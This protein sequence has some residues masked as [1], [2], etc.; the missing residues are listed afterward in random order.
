MPKKKNN[1]LSILIHEK[2]FFNAKQAGNKQVLE[3]KL[4]NLINHANNIYNKVFHSARENHVI[5][6]PL[7]KKNYIKIKNIID[8]QKISSNLIKLYYLEAELACIQSDLNALDFYPKSQNELNLFKEKLESIKFCFDNFNIDFE[9]TKSKGNLKNSE[10]YKKLLTYRDNFLNTWNEN[11]NNLLATWHYNLAENFIKNSLPI[12]LEYFKQSFIFY[13]Q[14]NLLKFANQTQQR[15]NKLERTLREN[16]E[17]KTESA[18]TASYKE[19]SDKLPDDVD[20]S[21]HPLVTKKIAESDAIKPTQGKRKSF[22]NDIKPA[23]KIRCETEYRKLLNEFEEIGIEKHYL[24]N[25]VCTYEF[26]RY[27]ASLASKFS[28][29]IIKNLRKNLSFPNK[30]LSDTEKLYSLQKAQNGFSYS[31]KFYNQ[32]GLLKEKG[33]AIQCRN[34]LTS[35]IEKL[36]G[37][38]RKKSIKQANSSTNR[39]TNFDKHMITNEKLVLPIRYTRTFFKS[40]SRPENNAT[41]IDSQ[42]NLGNKPVYSA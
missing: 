23:K 41:N 12:A 17:T 32:A 15:I 16:T 34:L 21:I 22:D 27:K 20:Q 30:K 3:D 8:S 38:S 6:F 37:L 29:D 31:I 7:C 28:L 4:R 1:N 39:K 19:A 40:L 26:N 9:K 25:P 33:K 18:W 36:N 10:A 42:N 14:A 13:K 11:S 5:N 2:E 35:T 24:H